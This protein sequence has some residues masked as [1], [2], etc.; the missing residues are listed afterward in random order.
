MSSHRVR[1][2]SLVSSYRWRKTAVFLSHSGTNLAIRH[3]DASDLGERSMT[4][5][6]LA[7]KAELVLDP[8][9]AEVWQLIWA[10]RRT[11]PRSRVGSLRRSWRA[12]SGWPTCRATR[13]RRPSP[14]REPSI[15]SSGSGVRRS[16]G[17]KRRVRGG[18]DVGPAV[19]ARNLLDDA[20]GEPVAARP[21]DDPVHITLLG[22]RRGCGRRRSARQRQSGTSR[23][24]P[25]R[26]GSG[27]PPNDVAGTTCRTDE[28]AGP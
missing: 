16:R 28:F 8:R 13:T 17:R 18:L 26:G 4:M 10:G 14:A 27:R 3:L 5:G 25:E 22:R 11:H 24:H 20:D 19:R 21:A 12:C 9:L 23:R 7:S 15:A 1:R 2:P 6:G